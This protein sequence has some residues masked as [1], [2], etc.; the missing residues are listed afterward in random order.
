MWA[1]SGLCIAEFLLVSAICLPDVNERFKLL[2]L[3]VLSYFS[4]LSSSTCTHS[5]LL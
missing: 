3:H 5:S 1:V 4:S 2:F